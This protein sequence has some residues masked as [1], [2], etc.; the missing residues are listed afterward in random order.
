MLL[1]ETLPIVGE[2]VAG[3]PVIGPVDCP[4]GGSGSKV[5]TATAAGPAY[6]ING[7][8]TSCYGETSGQANALSTDFGGAA[9][10]TDTPMI[11]ALGN[12][13]FGAAGGTSATD[14]GFIMGAI[15]LFKALDLQ[16][17]DYQSGQDLLGVWDPASGQFRSGFPA[18]VNDLQLLTGPA[19]GD[20]DGNGGE[21]VL[22]GSSS[23]DLVAY[24]PGGTP[25]SGWPKL[26]TD[27]TVA[28]P[29]IGSFGTEDT[30]ASARKVVV[31]ITRSGY[32]HAYET[33]AQACSPSS[34][35][36]FHHDN[37]NSGDYSRDA[38]L[39]GAP[40]E[41]KA[42]RG[43]LH[44]VAPGDDLLCGT[45]DHYELVTAK[46]KIDESSF[47]DAKPL[48]G[49]PQPK[50]PGFVHSLA[51]P[52][53]SKGW[54]AIRAVDEQGNVGRVAS[55]KAKPKPPKRR[56]GNEIHGTGRVGPADTGP[57]VAT[58]SPAGRATT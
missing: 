7:D 34:S 15:G 31:A 10:A 13:A 2:G 44:F 18:T 28:T 50:P 3:P 55:V 22:T 35:P 25:A 48:Q 26:T 46:Q 45:A 58:R 39:P 33:D 32:I 29:L 37:A 4:S 52:D 1:T 36:R 27:W 8:G 53:R 42:G 14:P 6:V 16:V 9:H 12:P 21:E 30:K 56:C 17:V 38:V 41:L 54:I 43:K 23:Q 47:A 11:P 24:G 49:A 57:A 40:A 51:I 20:V 5:G 19:V